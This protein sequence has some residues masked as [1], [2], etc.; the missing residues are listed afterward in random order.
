M[1]EGGVDDDKDEGKCCCIGC[2]MGGLAIGILLV[3]FFIVMLV[4]DGHGEQ[5]AKKLA[6]R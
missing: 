4:P 1:D 3:M 5:E 2:Q 6:M